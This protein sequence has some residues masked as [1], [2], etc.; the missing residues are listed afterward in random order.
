MSR[1][2]TLE[3]MYE[4]VGAELLNESALIQVEEENNEIDF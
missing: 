1:V 2:H 4:L 3:E